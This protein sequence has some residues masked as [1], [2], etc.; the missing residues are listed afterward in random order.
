MLILYR[1]VHRQN[2]VDIDDDGS[3]TATPRTLT[4]RCRRIAKGSVYGVRLGWL[5]HAGAAPYSTYLR[6]VALA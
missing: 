1:T 2:H 6:L 5:S 4:A 3:M